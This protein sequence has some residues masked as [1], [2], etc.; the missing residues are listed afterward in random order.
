MGC[1]QKE[2]DYWLFLHSLGRKRSGDIWEKRINQP[3]VCSSANDPKQMPKIKPAVAGFI[4]TP[5]FGLLQ[6]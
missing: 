5:K 2:G 1:L 4:N 3:L 6:K